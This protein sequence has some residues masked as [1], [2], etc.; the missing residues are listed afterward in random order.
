VRGYRADDVTANGILPCG[1][2][3]LSQIGKVDATPGRPFVTDGTTRRPPCEAAAM[4]LEIADFAILPGHEESFTAAFREAVV[5]L[6]ASRGFR[7]ARLTRGIESPARFVL[8]VEWEDLEAH[9]VGF[10]ESERFTRWREII[11]PFFDGPPTV[12]HV[13]DVAAAG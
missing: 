6:Q 2:D 12:E 3:V 4:V 1:A 8:L 11:G 13:V 7:S 10:R 9:T 5:Q